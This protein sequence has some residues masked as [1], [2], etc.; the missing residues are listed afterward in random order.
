MKNRTA[1]QTLPTPTLA[2]ARTGSLVSK[3]RA[4]R[5]SEPKIESPDLAAPSAP[6]R[7]SETQQVQFEWSFPDAKEVFI[8][9]S[10]NNWQPAATP[11]KSRGAGCWLLDLALKPGRYEYR[12]V[13]DGK[14]TDDPMSRGC[15]PNPLGGRNSVLIVNVD[16]GKN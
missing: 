1:E 11:L 6:P 8:A 9:G 5:I 13:V 15:G 7:A 3:G 14:W 12:F 16:N 2:P 4:Q 10:F